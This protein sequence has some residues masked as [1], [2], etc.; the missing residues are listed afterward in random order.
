MKFLTCKPLATAI[1]GAAIVSL[2]LAAASVSAQSDWPNKPIRIV[3]PYGAGSSP[4]VI[5]RLM[6]DKLSAKLGQPGAQRQAVGINIAAGLAQHGR[7]R[8][9]RGGVRTV[10]ARRTRLRA[11]RTNTSMP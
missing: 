11:T 8:L 9:E 10:K 5:A 3:V 6:G 1:K 2:A 7:L 4:D